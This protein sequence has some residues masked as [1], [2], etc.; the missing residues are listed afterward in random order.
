M[1]EYTGWI[2]RTALSIW[3]REGSLWAFPI[4]LILHTVG[5]AFLVGAN[6][7]LDVRM[8]GFARGLPLPSL[9]P[10]FKAMWLGFWINAVS[11]VLLLITYPTKA[12]T[13]PL[14][15]LKLGL[16]AF[17]VAHARW[18]RRQLSGDP[19]FGTTQLPR[20]VRLV[21]V[22]ALVCW[23]AAIT[24]G[25]LLAYTYSYLMAYEPR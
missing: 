5:L 19:G 1:F 13:N 15:Y 6:V 17:A 9:I 2:E 24:A 22:A 3:I 4:I 11:G 14:F 25:R 16:I 7:A 23:A 18:V 12:L 10:F 8:L 21:S 20:T